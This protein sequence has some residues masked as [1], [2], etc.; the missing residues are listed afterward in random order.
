[1]EIPLLQDIFVIFGLAVAVVFLCQLLRVP[2]IVGFLVTGVLAGPYGF[3]LVHAV[4]DVEVLAE[5]GVILLLFAIGITTSRCW[6][7]SA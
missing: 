7:R 2:P 4:H 6:P 3:G 1:M 5:I